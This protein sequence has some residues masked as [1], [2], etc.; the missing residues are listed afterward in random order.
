MCVP[1]QGYTCP[2]CKGKKKVNGVPCARCNATGR[3]LDIGFDTI[4]EVA[5]IKK[6][7]RR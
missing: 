7:S 6:K 3:V 5:P 2:D 1:E 4:A